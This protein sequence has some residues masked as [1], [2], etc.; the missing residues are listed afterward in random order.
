MV[1]SL[2]NVKLLLCPLPNSGTLISGF[3]PPPKVFKLNTASPNLDGG[4]ITPKSNSVGG[5]AVFV[6]P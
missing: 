3:S 2:I 5:C 4:L 6:S 1:S